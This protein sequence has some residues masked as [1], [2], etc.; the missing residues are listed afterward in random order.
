[1][2]PIKTKHTHQLN[3]EQR[4]Q[5]RQSEDEA[6]KKTALPLAFWVSTSASSPP[7]RSPA[8]RKQAIHLCHSSRFK[9]TNSGSLPRPFPVL[10][11]V[12]A[13]LGT[14]APT[15]VAPV[16]PGLALC[17][18]FFFHPHSLGTQV[19]HALPFLTRIHH[20]AKADRVASSA[21]PVLELWHVPPHLALT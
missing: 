14:A 1:M 3:S 18:F 17:I 19:S 10:A 4:H 6:Q 20:A 8:H 9:A 11:T 12:R 5:N 21:S 15:R 16:L 7:T 13:G 2:A